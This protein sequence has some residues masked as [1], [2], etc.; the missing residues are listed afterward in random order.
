MSNLSAQTDLRVL[1]IGNSYTAVNNL[2]EVVKQVA[3]SAGKTIYYQA[4]TPGGQTLQQHS[5]NATTLNLI[6]QGHWDFV[7]LQEQSQIPSFPDG[8]VASQFYP[9]VQKLDDSIHF[10]SPCA[11]TLLY[12]TWGRKN[13]D[14]ANCPNFPP[15]CTYEGMDDQLTTNYSNAAQQTHAFL[16]PVGPTWR[17]LRTNNPE[18]ELYQSDE[19][20]PSVIGTYAAA[21]TF[22]SVL[23]QATMQD[24]HYDFSLAASDAQKVRSAVQAVVADDLANWSQYGTVKINSFSG[25]QQGNSLIFDF[26]VSTEGAQPTSYFWDFGDGS[27]STEVSPTH[28]FSDSG[29]YQICVSAI[30]NC[31]TVTRCEN[32]HVDGT[33]TTVKEIFKNSV[34][35]S[36]NSFHA[37]IRVRG[38]AGG[39]Q[40]KICNLSGKIV[41]A[42]VAS[43]DE[44]VT[45]ELPNDLYFVQIRSNEG[46][47]TFK[48]L[49]N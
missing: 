31:D 32:V 19:S 4:S 27:T 45:D 49:K 35:L 41:K 38:V 29:E 5:S 28:T 2:P 23:F 21:C 34:S 39:F 33:T 12:I 40:Y 37:F 16:S 43:Q 36:P 3:A 25:I 44:I 15:L 1:F 9:Y 10:Y 7:V 14:Q 47:R 26:S 8:Q 46:V 20:H 48:M 13:G 6:R 11:K 18:L 24:V 17:Y 42:G 22:Y 30:R